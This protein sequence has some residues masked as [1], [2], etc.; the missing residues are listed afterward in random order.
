MRVL[1]AHYQEIALKGQNRP[2]FIRH[3]ARNLRDALAG[4]EVGPVRLPMGRV[5]IPLGDNADVD[6]ARR[7]LRTVC[8]LANFAVAGTV[9]PDVAAITTAVLRDLPRQRQVA[10]FRV[11]VRRA[12]KQFPVP[13]PDVERAI[14]ARINDE[15][16][17]PVD[18]SNPAFTVW[19][20]IVPGRA[21]YYYGKEAGAGG[22][23]VGTGGRVLVLLSGGI[24][25]PVAA[26][27]M[28]RRGCHATFVH[29]HGHPFTSRASIDKVRELAGVLAPYQLGAHVMFVPFGELQ[30]QV[31]MSVPAPMRV[32]VYRRLMMRIAAR[33]AATVHARALVTGDVVGQVASQTLDNLAV[34]DAA[35][36]LLTLRP[37]VGTTK[38]DIIAEAAALGSY[39]IS[40]LP[41]EDCCT[42]FTPR[43]PLTRVRLAQVEAAE[44]A[45]PLAQMIDAATATPDIE[46]I[47]W[48]RAPMV[49]SKAAQRAA[50]VTDMVFNSVA[51][52]TAA[53]A[54]TAAIT[55]DR[56]AVSGTPSAE[57]VDRLAHT[58]AFGATPEL[59]GT[60]RWV[61]LHL[62]AA[63]GVR[64][65]SIHDLYLAM[66]RG[67]AGGFTVPAI[68]VRT[69]AYDTGRAVMRA[70]RGLDAG[71]F[72]L[73]IARSE[74]GYTEQRP[75]EYAAI[76]AA[77]ALREGFRG[78]LFLQGDHVQVSLKK[79]ASPD[80]DKELETL[81]GLIREEIAAGFYNIDI[82][83]S[84]LVDLD[85]PTL[86]EQQAVNCELAADFTAFI[87]RCEPPDVTVSVGGEIGEVGGKNSDV[88]ELHAFMQGYNAALAAKGAGLIGISKISV[89]T[90]T[91]HGGFVG[92]DGKVKS[93]VKIDLDTLQELSRLAREEYG[94]A[95]AVQ[96]GASTLSAD[97]FDAFPR[98]GACEIH[99]ATNFQNMV[100]D[101]P[102]FP[103]PLRDEMYAW[104]REHAQEERKASDTEE[105]F[106]YKARKKAIGPFKARL[107]QLPDEVRATINKTLEDQFA[108]L[109]GKLRINNTSA[110]VAKFVTPAAGLPS[111]EQAR[112]AAAGI[113]TAEERK[114]EGLAD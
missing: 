13:S 15:T 84:T 74:I 108:F 7:R 80:R 17:W 96:H 55:G 106:L 112:Q 63:Q 111:L 52:L 25:S 79:Y 8:G 90:G 102:A 19:V 94:L 98:V 22:L 24:D 93:D 58:A 107:W 3:L 45:L 50:R 101:H 21:Y 95:G 32:V 109:M 72:I 113:I 57:L 20:E 31:T 92:P 104:V 105:Q 27:R 44:R 10:S 77:A 48:P 67:E 14:G 30:R 100:Y 36:D 33:L 49:Q 97:A 12:H 47:E 4:V 71:A 61:I 42:L 91:A 89:Q 1:L 66:G 60:A 11:E 37:L 114:A 43:H 41:D 9:A 110:V 83:T 82:D 5:E 56:I 28:I 62:A 46:H 34:V 103:A 6:E 26:W 39:P 23:P 65:A 70:A 35:T 73:E 40:I 88:H 78:P 85:K 99:L 2:W 51:D 59:K 86:A 76:M 69:I 87:R 64:F 68:N 16:G 54:G 38:E 81:R 53:L 18:L 75:H 29:F